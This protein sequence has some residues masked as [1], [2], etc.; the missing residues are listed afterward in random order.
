MVDSSASTSP[1]FFLCHMSELGTTRAGRAI[2][3][4]ERESLGASFQ[5]AGLHAEDPS[6]VGVLA[7]FRAILFE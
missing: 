2:G 7:P 6:Y 5:T 1:R 4:K 3:Q